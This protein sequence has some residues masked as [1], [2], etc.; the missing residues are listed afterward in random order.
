[1][2]ERQIR[3]TVNPGG[4][5]PA[6]WLVEFMR[7]VQFTAPKTALCHTDADDVFVIEWTEQ[8]GGPVMEWIV[9]I[10]GLAIIAV[11]AWGMWLTRSKVLD[12]QYQR[13]LQDGLK[14]ALLILLTPPESGDL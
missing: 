10:L 14:T 8:D 6:E 3:V 5:L 12:A 7:R 2:A 4:M 13:G 9:L 11:T 1:M